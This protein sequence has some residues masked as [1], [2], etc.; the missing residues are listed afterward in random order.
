MLTETELDDIAG[1]L[2]AELRDVVSVYRDTGETTEDPVT[3]EPVK[4]W[5]VVLQ[6]ADA[7]VVRESMNQQTSDQ[8]DTPQSTR[9][10][11][12]TLPVSATDVKSE[13]VVVV[14]QCH[15][16]DTTDAALTVQDPQ[17]GS[18]SISRRVRCQANLTFPR[19]IP[20]VGS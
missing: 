19:G 17:Y 5:E 11:S 18:L 20:E 7:L 13:D 15:D 1:D 14:E 8:G 16:P 4:V 12:V 3:Y 2:E 6:S 9:M 10:Y